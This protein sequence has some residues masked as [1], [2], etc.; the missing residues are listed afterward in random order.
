MKS[1]LTYF[2][3]FSFFISNSLIAQDTTIITQI[4]IPIL[5]SFDDV[6]ELSNGDIYSNST[7]LELVEDDDNGGTQVVG[8][9]FQDIPVEQGAEIT[10]AYIRFWTDEISTGDCNLQIKGEAAIDAGNFALT[11]NNLSNRDKTSATVDW[12]PANWLVGDQENITPDISEIIQELISQPD[13]QNG[14]SINLFIE[15]NGTRTAHSYEGNTALAPQ[16][17]LEVS[18]VYQKE[19]IENVYINE[20][21]AKNNVVLDEFGESDDWVE[22]Y[23]DND[24]G[25]MLQGLFVSDDINDSTKWQLPKPLLIQPKGFALLWLDD[26]PEQGDLHIPFKL[27]SDGESVMIAQMQGNAL[28]VLDEIIFDTLPENVSYGRSM[29]GQND[30]VE[31]GEY[32]PNASNNDNGLY[33]DGKVN[34]SLPSGYYSTNAEVELISSDP[35]A[36]IRFTTDGSIPD[37][38]SNIYNSSITLNNTTLI[39]A[40]A[41]KTGFVS[42]IENEEFYLIN[43]THSLPVVQLSIDPK[44]LWDDDEGMYVTGNNGVTGNCSDF[45]T[46]NWNQDWERPVSIRYFETDG[47]QAFQVDAGMKIGGGCSRGFAQKMFNVFLRNTEYGDS[48]VEYPLFNNL[49]FNEYK[50]FKLRTSGNDFPLTKI[51]DAAIQE[52]LRD[53]VDIDLMGYE[54]VV[55]YL[56]GEYWGLYGMREHFTKHYIEA[57]HGVNQDSIDLIKNPYTWFEVK[58]GSK[59]DWDVLTSFIQNNSLAS[60]S[61]YDYVTNQIDIYEFMNYHIAQ[62]YVANYDW[63]ANNSAVW[64]AQN[65]GKWRWMLFDLDISSG[66]GQ[67]SPATASFNAIAHSTTA[68]GPNWPNSPESTLF[69]RKIIQNQFF[70]NEYNQRMC[71]FGQTIFAPDRAGQFIDSLAQKISSEIQPTIDKFNNVSTDWF[72]WNEDP[73]GGSIFTW[74]NNL[75]TFKDF[76]DDRMGFMLT[77]FENH[78]NYDG[79]FDLKINYDETTNGTVV[80]HLNEM[81]IPFDYQGDYF[82]N[83]PIRVKAIPKPGYYFYKWLETGETSAVINFSSNSDAEL[84]PIFLENGTTSTIDLPDEIAFDIFPNPTSEILNFSIKGKES[85]D[86]WIRVFDAQ[87]KKVYV[88]QWEINAIQQNFRIH[89][90]EWERGIYFMNAT[91]GNREISKKIIIE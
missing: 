64:R 83:V 31:F 80:F 72:M 87:G 4:T 6:E 10:N 26:A 74:Q 73:V 29:D 41:F 65:G 50:R 84:T 43:G 1:T 36:E 11:S 62:M 3:I 85:S 27:S 66:F 56:N 57:H 58:E 39:K 21:M 47:N 55:V 23:N 7:D 68:F 37:Q 86:C 13:W 79:H 12:S 17:V 8:L 18:Q 53:Q 54:P 22:I 91:I 44:Y 77:H 71:T 45:I 69:F 19:N 51:R 76:F 20:L 28:V 42:N 61:N 82:K 70:Q 32:S 78:F 15:G 49:P 59:E 9:H 34:F 46:R 89:V 38:N 60:L 63:P 16:L 67:W 25:I 90:K 75:N 88:N 52:M 40:K 14:N 2:F 35:L 5:S 48:K 33:F 81:K 24:V 30:W